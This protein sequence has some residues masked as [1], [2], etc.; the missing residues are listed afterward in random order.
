MYCRVGHRE[1]VGPG[2]AEEMAAELGGA[3]RLGSLLAPPEPAGRRRSLG[4]PPQ[5]QQTPPR[6]EKK[7]SGCWW[8][9]GQ[10]RDGLAGADPCWR[11]VAALA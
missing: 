3:V 11:P 5:V 1:E 6:L 8:E 4:Q 2:Q 7:L 10:R 9:A